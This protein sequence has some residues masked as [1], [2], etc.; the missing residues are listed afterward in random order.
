MKY[1]QERPVRTVGELK[2]AL[3]DVPDDWVLVLN[4]KDDNGEGTA[5]DINEVNS[6]WHG[7][8]TFEHE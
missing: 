6:Y 2:K 5:V 7:A 4:H 3:E 1:E 8:L